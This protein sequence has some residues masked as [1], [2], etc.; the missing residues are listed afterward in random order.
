MRILTSSLL[1]YVQRMKIHVYEHVVEECVAP[2]ER[3]EPQPIRFGEQEVEYMYICISGMLIEEIPQ[4][5]L[6]SIHS[7]WMRKM[8]ETYIYIH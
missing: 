2:S 8:S 4:L 1:R 3:L 5:W 6:Q 7:G